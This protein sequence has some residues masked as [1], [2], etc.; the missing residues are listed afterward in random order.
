ML[1][2]RLCVPLIQP[3]LEILP[4]ASTTRATDAPGFKVCSD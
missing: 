3:P 2:P 1:V 4:D